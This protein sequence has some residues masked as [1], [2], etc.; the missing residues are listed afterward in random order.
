[1][2]LPIYDGQ[3]VDKDLVLIREVIAAHK[4]ALPPNYDLTNTHVISEQ[5][6]NNKHSFRKLRCNINFEN[7]NPLKM[8][9]SAMFQAIIRQ[10]QHKSFTDQWQ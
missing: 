7:E 3:S 1:M 2:S 4:E 6:L 9:H 5:H 10:Y 8:E